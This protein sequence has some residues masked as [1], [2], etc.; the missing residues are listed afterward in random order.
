MIRSTS[1]VAVPFNG[2]VQV[3]TLP[4]Y[5]GS[6]PVFFV[7][8]QLFDGSGRLLVN[9][10]Y[11]QSQK[12]DD[13]GARSHDQVM[14]LRQD[15]WADMTALNSMPPVAV[16]TSAKQIKAGNESHVTI[17]L[18]NPSQHIAFFER[19]T[20]LAKR[21]GDEILPIEY[22]DNYVTLYPGETAEIHGTIWNDTKPHWVKLEGYNTPTI[23]VRIK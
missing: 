8:C 4:R 14:T 11:W 15:K 21:D 12:D 5:P 13:L 2:E 7:R 23:S 10:V 17:R 20:I 18:R 19:A 22:D 9:N 16:E 1:H 3:L 6:S